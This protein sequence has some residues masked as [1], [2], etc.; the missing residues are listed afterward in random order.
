MSHVGYKGLFAAFSRRQL[1]FLKGLPS[2]LTVWTQGPLSWLW[3]GTTSSGFCFVLYWLACGKKK[4]T[5]LLILPKAILFS[6]KCRVSFPPS[7]SSAPSN[8]P[9]AQR[10]LSPEYLPQPL[11][12]VLHSY[13]L[14]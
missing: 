14:N 3:Q 9:H 8:C 2:T 10:L 6:H 7:R 11:L 1:S 12:P 4:K 5:T 13:C